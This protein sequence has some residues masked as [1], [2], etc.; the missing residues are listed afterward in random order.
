[1]SSNH[2]STR[3]N[4]CITVFQYLFLPQGGCCGGSRQLCGTVSNGLVGW[5]GP[6]VVW[7]TRRNITSQDGKPTEKVIHARILYAVSFS[8][9]RDIMAGMHGRKLVGNG[10]TYSLMLS[11]CSYRVSWKSFKDFLNC[12]EFQLPS[13]CEGEFGGYILR[14]FLVFLWTCYRVQ[15]TSLQ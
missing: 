1:M 5:E 14:G 6:G 15:I 10:S 11:E 2:V 7:E 12:T 9:S 4:C 3:F 13:L 8:G